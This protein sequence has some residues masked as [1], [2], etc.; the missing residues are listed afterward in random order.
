[1]TICLLFARALMDPDLPTDLSTHTALQRIHTE[2]EKAYVA[3]T[4]KAVP[5]HQD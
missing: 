3:L 1:M 5:P 4:G 2:G